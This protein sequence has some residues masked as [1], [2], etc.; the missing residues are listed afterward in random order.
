MARYNRVNIDFSKILK[1]FK[2]KKWLYV[3]YPI[4]AVIA[5]LVFYV[6]LPAI[7][8]ANEGFWTYLTFILF[9]CVVPFIFKTTTKT[10]KI[11]Q[12]SNQ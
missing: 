8:F 4:V 1:L 12:G 9:L 2:N 10:T 5:F 7:N 11:C 6:T 3:Y